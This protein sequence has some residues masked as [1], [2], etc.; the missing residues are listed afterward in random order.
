MSVLL[1]L[2]VVCM[3]YTV[4]LAWH[5]SMFELKRE[6]SLLGPQE[7]AHPQQVVPLESLDRTFSSPSAASA[8]RTT[9]RARP[10][11]N[12]GNNSNHIE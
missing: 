9:T 6:R 7:M 5:K 4:A 2:G 10:V 3:V 11:S 12:S 8:S 1:A